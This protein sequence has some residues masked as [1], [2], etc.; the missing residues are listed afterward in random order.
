MCFEVKRP[1]LEARSNPPKEVVET[2][3]DGGKSSES[4]G[5]PSSALGSVLVAGLKR[6]L[7]TKDEIFHPKHK[8][9]TQDV[10]NGRIL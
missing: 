4:E 3:E 2:V 6:N 5:T 1:P 7:E 8:S 9:S 10:S